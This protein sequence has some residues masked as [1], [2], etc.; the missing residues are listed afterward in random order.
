M[1]DN[2]YIIDLC[3]AKVYAQKFAVFMGFDISCDFFFA[4]G[5]VPKMCG[6]LKI[7]R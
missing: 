5:C 1:R 2:I 6:F 3:I 4:G 7:S